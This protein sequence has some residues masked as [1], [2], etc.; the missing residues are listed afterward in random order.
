[1]IKVA[2]TGNI[3]SGKSSVQDIISKM[4]FLVLDTDECAHNLL[5]GNRE[6]EKTF[7]TSD[8]SKLAKI[9]F[10][11]EPKLKRLEEIL[12]PLVR[13]EILKFFKNNSQ[14]EILFV[15]VPQLFEAGFENLFDKIIFV[16]APYNLRL[17]RLKKRNNYDE[18]YAKLR[19]DSQI[20]SSAKIPKCDYVINNASSLDELEKNTKE[21]LKLLL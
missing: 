4:G 1:M 21:C 15:A 8:R 7:G 13:D 16:D 6:V 17:E 9:V 20:D 10:S 5:K 12:H 18:N 3:A 14:N 19:L 2:L 11:D